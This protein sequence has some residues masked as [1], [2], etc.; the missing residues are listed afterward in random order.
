[1]EASKNMICNQSA[2][3]QDQECIVTKDGH[4]ICGHEGISKLCKEMEW[5]FYLIFLGA[6]LMA[7]SQVTFKWKCMY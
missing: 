2:A 5:G 7:G 1:M 3:T 4:Q 6:I